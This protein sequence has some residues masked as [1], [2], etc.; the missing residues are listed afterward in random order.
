MGT[1]DGRCPLTRRPLASHSPPA[2]SIDSTVKTATPFQGGPMAPSKGQQ[3]G[4][5]VWARGPVG[6][7][8]GP[9]RQASPLEPSLQGLRL[10]IS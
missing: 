8:G 10:L 7:S 6:E 1:A 4:G 9:A 5:A 3:G 2:M